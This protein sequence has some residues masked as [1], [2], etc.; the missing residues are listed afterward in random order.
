M[1][2]SS[3]DNEAASENDAVKIAGPDLVTGKSIDS[4]AMTLTVLALVIMA[5]QALHLAADRGGRTTLETVCSTID[6]NQA[7]WYEFTV[8][9]RI[10]ESLAR[11]I[12]AYR[13]E[14]SHRTGDGARSPV[15]HSAA[16]LDDVRGIGP[17]TVL[18]IA[19]HLR[20]D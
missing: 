14:A 2:T 17:K 4:Q 1:T 16:D 9:P 6:P 15:F 5:A 8:L 11:R 20:F 3:R 7:P 10:G 19:P 18:R 13:T 12:T